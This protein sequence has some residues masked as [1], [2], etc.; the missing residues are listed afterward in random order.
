M[1]I[2]STLL[3][4]QGFCCSGI[5]PNDQCDAWI[6]WE[7]SFEIDNHQ[8]GSYAIAYVFYV[9]FAVIFAAA[10]SILVMFYAP[11]SRLSG[12]PE[13]K[14]I[15]S[16]FIIRESLGFK[17]LIFKAIGLI[18][19]VSAGLWIGKEGPLVH[20][21]CCCAAVA[22]QLFPQ[23]DQNEAIKREV[24]AAASSAGI[25]VAFGSPIGGVLFH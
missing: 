21:A 23:L 16:G 15:L 9:F 2:A 19:V 7:Q 6:T 18:L 20:V 10:G 24:L 12:I 3:L 8:V 17:T 25:S 5:D 11:H 14:T 22:M 13:I 4:T 1:A